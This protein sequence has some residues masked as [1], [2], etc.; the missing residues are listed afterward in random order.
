MQLNAIRA[1]T[2]TATA[3]DVEAS[4]FL[5]CLALLNGVPLRGKQQFSVF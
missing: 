4:V 2:K 5:F 1:K 3:K